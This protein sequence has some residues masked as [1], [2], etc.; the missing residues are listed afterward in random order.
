MHKN[1][2]AIYILQVDAHCT[3]RGESHLSPHP[4]SVTKPSMEPQAAQ[5]LPAARPK[6]L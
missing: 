5:H 2:Y 3:C 4:H 6:Q 1:V